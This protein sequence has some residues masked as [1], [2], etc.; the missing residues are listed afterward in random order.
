MFL[1]PDQSTVR[2]FTVDENA[3]EGARLLL[4]AG[5]LLATTTGARVLEEVGPGAC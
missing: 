4:E 1:R 3:A 5:G 2:Y